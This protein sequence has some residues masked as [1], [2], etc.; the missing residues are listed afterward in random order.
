[1]DLKTSDGTLQITVGGLL[2]AVPLLVTFVYIQV[3][4][5]LL[6]YGGTY[7]P[8]LIVTLALFIIPFGAIFSFRGARLAHR[9][10]GLVVPAVDLAIL[11]AFTIQFEWCL[12]Y[13]VY[14]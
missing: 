2:S 7:P 11:L 8:E 4:D 1:L 9:R 13:C 6:S 12:R 3:I 14:P 10:L 5:H